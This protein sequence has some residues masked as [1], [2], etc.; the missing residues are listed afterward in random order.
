M[1]MPA[2]IVLGY[3]FVVQFL[4][5]A[6]TSI[7]PNNPNG[8]GVAFWAHV[9]GFVSGLVL[10]SSSL[11]GRAAIVTESRVRA[12]RIDPCFRRMRSRDINIPLTQY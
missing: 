10:I 1:W 6:A 8:A 11:P 12:V 9:G 4:S 7:G 3:W 2:W 5:G